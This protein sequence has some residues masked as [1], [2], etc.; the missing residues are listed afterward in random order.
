MTP[1]EETAIDAHI[2]KSKENA[3]VTL[4]SELNKDKAFYSRAIT[5][6]LRDGYFHCS[7]DGSDDIVGFTKILN[8]IGLEIQYI[9]KGIELK[10][11]AKMLYRETRMYRKAVEVTYNHEKRFNRVGKDEPEEDKLGWNERRF[12]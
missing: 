10:D 6:L 8:H 4:W 7:F 5:D 11:N 1:A 2:L 9:S 3:Y 12:K